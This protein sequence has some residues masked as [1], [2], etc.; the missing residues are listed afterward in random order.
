M[1]QWQQSDCPVSTIPG[2]VVTHMNDH[3]AMVKE[4]EWQQ[5]LALMGRQGERV[6]IDLLMDCGIFVTIEGGR[7]NYH[8]LSG[9][10]HGYVFWRFC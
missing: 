4:C 5:L 8:Q 6:M 2:V 9:T 1:R 3:V 10:S 7:G